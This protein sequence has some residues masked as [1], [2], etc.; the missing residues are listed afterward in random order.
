[1]G[2]ATEYVRGSLREIS[3]ARIRISSASSSSSHD[4]GRAMYH[5]RRMTA[6]AAAREGSAP[7]VARSPRD[8][9]TDDERDRS[10]AFGIPPLLLIA[11]RGVLS[12]GFFRAQLRDAGPI[13]F[14][15][16]EICPEHQWVSLFGSVDTSN[17]VGILVADVRAVDIV[18]VFADDVF[19]WLED[20]HGVVR[21][22]LATNPNNAGPQ[23]SPPV[24]QGE[25]G[26]EQMQEML[27]VLG[28]MS[29]TTTSRR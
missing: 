10:R 4:I 29:P 8:L 19:D 20:E 14:D 28:R 9:L 17:V 2:L 18:A 23:I 5:T 7:T 13:V 22:T 15:R 3:T 27:D 12:R 25:I 1:M 24:V 6:R 26:V 21:L 16:C 11:A